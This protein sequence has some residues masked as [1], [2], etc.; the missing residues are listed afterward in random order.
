M[1]DDGDILCAYSDLKIQSVHAQC[2]CK[3][4]Y[5]PIPRRLRTLYREMTRVVV[6]VGEHIRIRTRITPATIGAMW[7]EIESRTDYVRTDYP[8]WP[9]SPRELC[10]NL[11]LSVD[12]FNRATA[13]DLL[14][15][16]TR[17]APTL[18]FPNAVEIVRH[19]RYRVD[20]Q[21]VLN[22]SATHRDRVT[23]RNTTVDG[24]TLR[25]FTRASILTRKEL[26]RFT[27]ASILTRKEL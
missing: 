7:D 15:P 18:D 14:S 21:S 10:N 13:R 17:P 27:R 25:R 11:W 2:I 4:F 6:R 8:R 23:D 24:R 12:D 22:L 9:A 16:L 3:G 5:G 20:W 1:R 19:R 26:R